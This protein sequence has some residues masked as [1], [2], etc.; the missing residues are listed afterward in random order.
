MVFELF[1]L[2]LGLV[3]IENWYTIE[4]QLT[5]LLTKD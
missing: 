4:A 1:S 5:G 2:V 3:I